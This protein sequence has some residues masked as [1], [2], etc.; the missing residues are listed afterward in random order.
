MRGSLRGRHPGGNL[1]GVAGIPAL[2]EGIPASLRSGASAALGRQLDFAR[3]VLTSNTM[4]VDVPLVVNGMGHYALCVAPC[5]KERGESG[6][7]S[8]HSASNLEWAHLKERPKFP[9]CR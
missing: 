7:G 4:G 8:T 3:N 6:R 2:D 9:K 5:G 1:L